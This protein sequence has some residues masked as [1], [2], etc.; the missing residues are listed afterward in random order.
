MT[1]AQCHIRNFGVRDHADAATASPRAGLPRAPNRALPTLNFQIVPSTR[2]EAYTLDFMADQECK[3][4]AFL[5][6]ELGK[7]PKLTCTL[8]D[9]NGPRVT[10]PR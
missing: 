10:A 6:A 5:T 9:P 1:C 2:W 7:A 3:A 4:Q 8:T